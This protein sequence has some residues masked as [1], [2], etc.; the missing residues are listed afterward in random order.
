MTTLTRKMARQWAAL[1]PRFLPFADAGTP[2][3]PLGRLLRLSL[4]QISV[5]M[6][7]VLLTG[8][9]NRVMIVELGVPAALVAI[10][11]G[12]PLVFAPLRALIGFRS[13][14]HRSYLGWRRI[15]YIWFGSL[16]QFGGLAI[17]PF[18]LLLL[19]DN[20]NGPAFAGQ[21][22]AALAFL[23][24]GAGMHT[25]QTAGLALACDLSS[26]DNRPRVV[27]LLQVM[28][29]VGM[30]LSAL[31]MGL[32]LAEFSAK[33]L[34][35]VVQGVALASIVITTFAV[36][37]QEPRNPDYT[38][39][40][41]PKPKFSAAWRTFTLR[42]QPGRLLVAVA[43]GAAAF[44]MQ[45]VLLE[46]FGAEILALSVGET[47]EL[48][49]LVAGGSLAGFAVAA[50]WLMRKGDPCRIAATGV[51]AGVVAFS[52]VI[53]SGA[54]QLTILF[55]VGAALIGFGSGLFAIGTLTAAMTM[56]REEESGLALGAWGAVQ[57]TALGCALT[58]GGVIRDVTDVASGSQTE[59]AI[60]GYGV[61][62]HLEIALLFATLVALGPLVRRYKGRDTSSGSKFGLAELP[63]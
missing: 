5:G 31:L 4:F 16:L 37:K 10:M 40:D 55:E 13:D 60:R 9:L 46:P 45:D 11:I 23:L 2:E 51:L 20:T 22:G 62:Y 27:A 7:V 41:T 35:Q 44:G 56:A 24:A 57:A 33:R 14:T 30:V 61:V 18:A 52:A 36:W 49:A 19:S 54:L 17:M 21:V 8:T 32:L 50:R 43:L 6:T 1:S 29:L 48:T 53:V 15:P 26:E 12:L 28:Q 47:T 63:G 38:P 3:L 25:T 59:A 34:I 42:T 39:R 58:L